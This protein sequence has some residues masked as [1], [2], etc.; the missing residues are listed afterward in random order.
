MSQESFRTALVG[1]G[2]WATPIADALRRS[3][4]IDLVA[5][6][7][8]NE[9]KRASFARE[10]GCEAASSYEAILKN[11]DVEGVLLTTPNKV[12]AAQIISALEAGKHVWVEKPITN[13]LAEAPEVLKAWKASDKT[14][15][16]GQCYRR[17]AGH[18]KIRALIEDGTIGRP[19]WAEAVFSNHMGQ[20]FT[21]EKWRFFR[22][23]CPG[24]PLMQ[25]G[26]HHCD[27]LNYLL[28]EPVSVTGIHKKL[29]TPAEIDDVTM[30][31]TEHE[32]GPVS[33]LMTSFVTPGVF[34][35]KLHGTQ[36]VVSL[37]MVR[38]NITLAH[39]TND[40]TTLAIQK[41]GEAGWT[42]VSVPEMAD[43]IIDEVEE[44]ADC[45]RTG[46]APETG[47]R[48]AVHALALVEGSCR[49]AEE[50][51]KIQMTELLDGIDI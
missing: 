11:P 14:L 33:T 37:E 18:R 26:I 46:V 1:L 5:C 48:E 50:G 3:E 2:W 24:G 22:D 16:V 4:K 40:E 39:R 49:S 7:T 47:P 43:M 35:L 10:H 6:Y 28:G 32:G 30:T 25:M 21:P 13:V 15:A 9:G 12:H 19:L 36:A 38:E 34:T 42:G 8:R 29:A 20:F 51:R 44:F 45:A 31:I 17:A 23:E 27:T 41:A